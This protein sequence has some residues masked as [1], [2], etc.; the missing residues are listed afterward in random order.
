LKV[1]ESH[2]IFA[3]LI[4]GTATRANRDHRFFCHPHG[5]GRE[6]P[7]WSGQLSKT[8]SIASVMVNGCSQGQTFNQT[9]YYRR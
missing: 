9:R 8:I 3:L 1:L 6:L 5:L 4:W 7:A 2:G